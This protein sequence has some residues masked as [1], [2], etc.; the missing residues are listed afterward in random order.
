MIEYILKSNLIW[1]KHSDYHYYCFAFSYK[2]TKSK[3]TVAFTASSWLM[4]ITAG[5]KN[6]N[7][8]EKVSDNIVY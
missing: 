8:N 4:C 5:I 2:I 6:V 3:I 1:V 7:A